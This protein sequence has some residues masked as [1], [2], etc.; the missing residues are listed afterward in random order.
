MNYN[1][2]DSFFNPQT[3]A[4]VGI[5]RKPKSLGQ[6]ILKNILEFGYTGHIYPVNPK[7]ETIQNI[8]C[9]KNLK[10]IPEAIDLVIIIV[11][12]RHVK[13]VIEESIQLG[14]QAAIIIT[15]GFSEI[16][17]D[18]PDLEAELKV[19][20]E[21]SGMRVLGPNSMGLF[22]GYNSNLQATFS[23]IKPVT[24]KIGFLSQSGSIGVVMMNLL[25]RYK[26]GMSKFVSLGN[27]MDINMNHMLMNLHKDPNTEVILIY[28]ES[29]SDARNFQKITRRISPEKP[30]VM[31]KSGKTEVGAKAAASHTGALA[32]KETVINAA[33]LSSGVIRVNS[34]EDMFATSVGLLKCKLPENNRVA[35]VSSAGGPCTLATDDLIQYGLEVPELSLKT[36]AALQ[37]IVPTEGSVN[38]PVDLIASADETLHQESLKII[39]KDP[40]IDS[41]LLIMVQPVVM[42]INSL[43]EAVEMI[44]RNAQKPIITSYM[45]CNDLSSQFES[46]SFAI[47]ESSETAV[48][49]IRDMVWYA[50][51]K[52]NKLSEPEQLLHPKIVTAICQDAISQNRNSLEQDE[53]KQLFEK[54]GFTFP[55]SRIVTTKEELFSAINTIQFPVV[56]KMASL[57]ISHKSDSGGVILDIRSNNEASKAW[58]T[59]QTIYS[60][61]QVNSEDRA[62]LVQKYYPDGIEVALGSSY[63]TQF[64]HQIMIGM[65]GTFIELLNDTSFRLVGLNRNDV[66]DMI[67]RLK[68]K[69]L[70]HGFRGNQ[71]IDIT[72]VEDSLLQLD[73]LITD[74][75]EIEELDI[76]PLLVIPGKLSPIVIDARVSLRKMNRQ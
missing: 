34:I 65:G 35:V 2:F 30:I 19:I 49:V 45:G 39:L 5:S 47:Y 76:N 68:G 54:Y 24:G 50:K 10:T 48:K 18:G 59:I 60:E 72:V 20:T 36:Q 21:N 37:E 74:N 3:I 13:T 26:L 14:V 43:I 51:W 15:A 64:G 67:D 61:H 1:S 8:S 31:V 62:I 29:F 56:I 12:S 55:Q 27:K 70:F 16:G 33:L 25:N 22:H 69:T 32:G 58:T 53:I 71:A 28:A 41:I 7:A 52:A 9:Y 11:P 42:E 4:V 57:Q 73:R 38:N 44:A 40:H 46:L 17:G 66:K 6:L 75:P 23:P 63:D